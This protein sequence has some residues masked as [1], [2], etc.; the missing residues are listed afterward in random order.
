MTLLL[1]GTVL[2]LPFINIRYTL[3]KEVKLHFEIRNTS[4]KV[5]FWGTEKNDIVL[6]EVSVKMYGE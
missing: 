2:F 6:W 5:Q 1:P 4:E 3:Y